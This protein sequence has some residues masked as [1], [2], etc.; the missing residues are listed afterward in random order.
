MLGVFLAVNELVWYQYRLR[1][2]GIRFPEGLPLQLSDLAVWLTVAAA[3]TRRPGVFEIAYFAGLSGAGMAVLT[4]DLWAPLISYPTVYFFLAHGGVIAILLMLIW[5][6]LLGPRPG[7]PWRAFLMLNVYAGAVGL[8]N[9]V[10][11]TNYMYLCRKPAGASLLDFLG[12][13]PVYL[14]A[15]EAVALGLFLILWL[16]FRKAG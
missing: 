12:P 11:D 14:L 5:G 10:Y 2:E 8:F 3:V 13:W 1:H 6:K 9:A 15:G 4:P 16:P 7:S